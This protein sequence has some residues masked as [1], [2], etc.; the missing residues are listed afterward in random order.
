MRQKISKSSPA[1]ARLDRFLQ[2]IEFYAV[3]M[4]ENVAIDT[5]DKGEEEEEVRERV[6][7]KT[8]EAAPGGRKARRTTKSF[9][10]WGDDSDEDNVFH[11]TAPEVRVAPEVMTL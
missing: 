7:S 5:G 1:Y 9:D 10:E 2:A 6:E 11:S 3:G 4:S 8:E